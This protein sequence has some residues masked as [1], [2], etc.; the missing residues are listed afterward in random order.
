[1]SPSTPFHELA[2][3]VLLTPAGAVDQIASVHGQREACK[4][5]H[6]AGS[7]LGEAHQEWTAPELSGGNLCLLPVK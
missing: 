5:V 6:Q 7:N 4:G 1:M 3:E 2:C